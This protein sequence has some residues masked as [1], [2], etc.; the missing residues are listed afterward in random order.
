MP[1]AFS[2]CGI[3]PTSGLTTISTTNNIVNSY[4]P[5]TGSPASGA[6]TLTVGGIDARGNATALS[7][8]DMVLI[9]QIQGADFNTANGD[10]YGDGVSGGIASGY[11]STNLVAGKYEYN[12]VSSYNSGTGVINF[13]YTLANNYYTRSY[14]SGNGIQAYQVIRI[15]RYYDLTINASSSITAPAWNGST[16]GVIVLEA[17][18]I[19]TINGSVIADALGFRGGGGKQ[20]TGVSGGNT[21]GSSAIT[22]TDY[23]W[24]SPLTKAANKTGGAKGEGIAG[25]PAYVLTNGA[26]NATTQALEGYTNGSMGRGAPGNAGGGGTDGDP[27]QNQYNPGGGGGGNGGAG[28]KGGSGWD[29]GSGNPATYATGGYGGAAFAEASLQRFVLGGGGGAGTSN[30]STAGTTDYLSSGACGGGII[31]IRGKSYSGSGTVTANGAA[32]NNQSTSGVTDAAGGGGAG[33]TIILVTNQS[34]AVGSNTITAS[35]SGGKGGDMTAYWAHGPGGGGGGGV[36]ISNVIPSASMTVTGGSNGLTRS[37]S[38]SGPIDNVYG[39]SSGSAGI[40]VTMA[41]FTGLA[42][43]GNAA[44]ACG[45]LPITLSLWNGVYRNNKTWLT[46]KAEES[47]NFSYFEIEHSTDGVQFSPIGQVTASATLQYT[48]VDAMPVNGVNFYRLKMVDQ[49]GQY[50]YS[51]IIILR[52]NIKEFNVS[53]MPNPFTDHV[54]VSITGNAEETVLLR[55]FNGEGKLVW[56]KTIA[57]TS[58]TNSQYLGDLQSLPGGV[59][60]LKVNRPAGDAGFKLLKK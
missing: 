20:L 9:I 28:G 15:P 7:N 41:G 18:D 32:A 44:S 4:Y 27:S 40:K 24:N 51:G 17:A 11:L 25:T 30:N 16:G 21:N 37:T 45:T 2:Q 59:Y 46:W 10:T 56:R 3:A 13:S 48:F 12:I 14:S 42:N 35:A 31:I 43:A 22:N 8:G 55:L 52:T 26:T 23:R 34:G 36:I 47:I 58:G 19:V 6:N 33:G 29:G 1:S 38:T 54:V 5:G 57:I 53:V 39:S 60:F 49:N 50:K